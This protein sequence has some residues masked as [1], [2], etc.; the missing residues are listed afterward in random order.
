[1]SPD[2]LTLRPAARDVFPS[3]A[4]G[5]VRST[6]RRESWP[7]SLGPS[8][9]RRQSANASESAERHAAADSPPT[10][11]SALSRTDCWKAYESP[12][13]ACSAS[14]RAR[15]DAFARRAVRG[16]ADA[17]CDDRSRGCTRLLL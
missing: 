2:G 10:I 12:Q 4:A 5:R 11:E 17:T 1:M 7:R 8:L 14:A 6:G 15:Q 16:N 9:R 13:A 3:L